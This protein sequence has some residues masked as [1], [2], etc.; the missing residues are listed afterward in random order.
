MEVPVASQESRRICV[1]GIDLAPDSMIL[2]LEFGTAPKKVVFFFNFRTVN[3]R[4]AK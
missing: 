4:K 1:R 2:R 3:P